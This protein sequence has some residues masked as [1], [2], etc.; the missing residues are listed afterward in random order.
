MTSQ[1]LFLVATTLI[2]GID[3]TYIVWLCMPQHAGNLSIHLV[4]ET[5]C[6]RMQT[7]GHLKYNSF[8]LLSPW[9]R[10]GRLYFLPNVGDKPVVKTILSL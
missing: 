2:Y 10:D 7:L 5:F 8:E 4:K 3:A 6:D 1:Q 9:V